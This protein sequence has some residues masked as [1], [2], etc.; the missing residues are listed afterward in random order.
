MESNAAWKTKCKEFKELMNTRS[1]FN[2]YSDPFMENCGRR[3]LL[4]EAKPYADFVQYVAE[5]DFDEIRSG[6]YEEQT[7]LQEELREI[8]GKFSDETVNIIMEFLPPDLINGRWYTSAECFFI[9]YIPGS[10]IGNFDLNSRKFIFLGSWWEQKDGRIRVGLKQ[11]ECR[12]ERHPQDGS[13]IDFNR[14]IWGILS[15][16][17]M[18]IET[19]HSAFCWGDIELLRDAGPQMMLVHATEGNVAG[20]R[21]CI[22]RKSYN[23][24]KRY[25]LRGGVDALKAALLCGRSECFNYLLKKGA[26]YMQAKR[27]ATLILN[28]A[29]QGIVDE[30]DAMPLCKILEELPVIDDPVPEPVPINFDHP[31]WLKVPD[32]TL[33]NYQEELTHEMKA[34]L[35]SFRNSLSLE[36]LEEVVLKWHK[37][38][39]SMGDDERS[40]HQTWSVWLGCLYENEAILDRLP[41]IRLA[42][43]GSAYE[44]LA[45]YFFPERSSQK[46]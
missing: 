33:R 46:R 14:D 5:L 12:K 16:D 13:G 35:D 17:H 27:E 29:L 10:F 24:D 38:L 9:E 41:N 32:Y 26:N 36:D 6:Y 30:P 11:Y 42:H 15:C 40:L 7:K 3:M 1:V 8:M 34:D 21:E 23:I 2:A 31:S 18:K 22:E 20:L 28:Q 43:C 4:P 45:K 19:E 37:C 39:R 25:P 44:Y